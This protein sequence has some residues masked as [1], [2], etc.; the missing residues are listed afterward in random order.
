VA[1]RNLHCIRD[2]QTKLRGLSGYCKPGMCR[3]SGAMSE[4]WERQKERV[5]KAARV[6]DS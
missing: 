4:A 2:K 6:M 1:F 3:C 5:L